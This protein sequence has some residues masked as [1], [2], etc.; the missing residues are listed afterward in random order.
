MG[1]FR[2]ITCSI[3]LCLALFVVSCGH[4]EK[5]QVKVKVNSPQDLDKEITLELE[6]IL[7]PDSVITVDSC[8]LV[9]YR[10]F[11]TLYESRKLLWFKSDKLNTNGDSLYKL[12]STCGYYGLYTETYHFQRILAN[13]DSIRRDKKY[14]NVTALTQ[15][16]LLLSNAYF[17]MGAHL[18]KGRLYPDSLLLQ[19]RFGALKHGWDSILTDAFKNGNLR[20]GLDSLEPKHYNYR[21][22][23]Q[24]LALILNDTTKFNSDSVAFVSE[25]DSLKVAEEIVKVLTQ[26][27]LYNRTE[28]PND[29]VAL[30]KALNK[31]QKKWYIQPDGKLGK[32]TKQALSYNRAKVIKQICMAMERWRWEQ[33]TFPKIYTWI[34]IPA[35]ELTVFEADTVVM[36]SAV[37]CGKPE[38]QTPILKSKIDHMLIYPYW[39][40][41][42]SIAWKE[43]LPAVQHDTT[44]IRRKNFEVIGA[45]NKVLDYTKLPWRRYSKEYLPVKFRQRI[46]EENSLGVVKFNFYNPFGVYL[47]DTNSKRYFKTSSRAQSHGCIR[48]EKFTEFADL[49]IRDDSVHY[50]H[51]SLQVYFSKQ[52][53]RKLKLKKQM[54]I[55]TRY[56]TAWADSTGLK[57]YLDVYR[58]DEKMMELIYKP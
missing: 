41:P 56:Y 39:N 54:P 27:G 11:K 1:L 32:Y 34:N 45:N 10:Y 30:A 8:S 55:Y 25:H 24:E 22:L 31:L 12:L 23:K 43:I 18:N 37:V 33:E 17:L 38:N 47:H 29:S 6:K 19:I 58:K 35:F 4:E 21:M 48:L 20:A 49:L 16:D 50:T 36:Q 2:F 57:L 26:Q 14:I 44:Y 40:V 3:I 28:A 52:E 7:K 53:Q 46:G 51:D 42:Y 15:A 9:C 13:M 5:A